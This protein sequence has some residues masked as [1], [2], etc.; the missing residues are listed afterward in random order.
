MSTARRA[1]R[2]GRAAICAP[3]G[4]PRGRLPVSGCL[5]PGHDEDGRQASERGW[6]ARVEAEQEEAS[7][8]P[9]PSAPAG[10]E[11]GAEAGARAR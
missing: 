4:V 2:G 6:K 1:G 11:G 10:A 5:C 9:G 8:A 7:G 3:G